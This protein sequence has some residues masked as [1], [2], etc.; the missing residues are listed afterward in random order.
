LREGDTV[1]VWKI[2][3][4]GR[5]FTEMVATMAELFRRDINIVATTQGI[6]TSTPM[7][8]AMAYIAGV[9]AE[10]EMEYIRERTKGALDERRKRGIHG[11]RKRHPILSDP[12][13]LAAIR[14]LYDSKQ[15]TMAQICE[16]HGLKDKT[17]VYRY[18]KQAP[19][20]PT[21]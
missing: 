6:D 1:V 13:K 10:M 8:K 11:G 9:F 3:R 16:M 14:K 5:N 17:T 21:R 18:L 20:Q 12:P 4:L 7:G 15:Y 19:P 2:D